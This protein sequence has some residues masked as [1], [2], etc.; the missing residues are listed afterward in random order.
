MD[1]SR[2]PLT[3]NWQI[4]SL[5]RNTELTIPP[6]PTAPTY[7][8]AS[9]ADTP[10]Q[11]SQSPTEACFLPMPLA[12]HPALAGIPE[13]AV[14]LKS[15]GGRNRSR[16]EEMD[17]WDRES[18]TKRWATA[19]GRVCHGLPHPRSQSS[20]KNLPIHYDPCGDRWSQGSWQRL[21]LQR[22]PGLNPQSALTN[23]QPEESPLAFPRHPTTPT[24]TLWSSWKK[25]GHASH[26][27]T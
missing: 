19:G 16:E 15:C 6:A 21:R 20:L 7:Q 26:R 25:A 10:R 22:Q 27:G 14:V 9:L 24:H 11:S 5:N 23:S 12:P 13:Q 3:V 8:S 18:N 17:G 4:K 1:R 2:K